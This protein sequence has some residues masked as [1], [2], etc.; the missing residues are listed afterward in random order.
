VLQLID[1]IDLLLE[2]GMV[3]EVLAKRVNA[4]SAVFI[5]GGDITCFDG[6]WRSLKGLERDK[7]GPMPS[8]E[9]VLAGASLHRMNPRLTLVVS[10][11]RSNLEGSEKA[12]LIATVM[13]AELEELG[14]SSNLIV[15][16]QASFATRDHFINCSVIAQQ[17]GWGATEIGIVSLFW[18]FGR[19]AAMMK[20]MEADIAPFV[21]G[22]TSF[23]SVE[24]I[25]MSEDG[26]K[27]KPYFTT[28]YADAAMAKTLSDEAVG[29]G[30]LWTGH[31]P[32]FG[33]PYGGFDDPLAVP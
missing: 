14:V 16:E 23:L 12:P 21:L 19:I 2:D 13:K 8:Y 1:A 6:R 25:L 31:A 9:R 20:M 4:L 27:W 11:G 17:R 3:D 30:Q 24:R 15:E 26:A 18:H 28:L 33:G 32:K 7:T 29:T 10:A 5:F 22:R